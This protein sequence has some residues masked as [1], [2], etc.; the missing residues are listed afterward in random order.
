MKQSMTHTL[1]PRRGPRPTDEVM[2]TDLDELER[3]YRENV[4]TVYRYASSRLGK[5]RGEEITGDVFHAA[6]VAFRQ[7]RGHSVTTA[8]LVAVCK[9]K[10][11][12]EWR[13]A[14]SRR[15]K[16]LLL[17]PDKDDLV[18]F[19]DDWHHDPRREQVMA[20][21]DRCSD[22]HRAVL[23]LHYVDSMTAV[24]IAASLDM[25]TSAIESLLA[26]ARRSFRSH[27]EPELRR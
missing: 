24:E 4:T 27:Y 13:K 11:I 1:R 2:T 14:T 3:I 23:I 15:T 26:R 17:Q 22:A 6:A 16:D 9:N 20:A 19:P 5:D 25:S 21:L 10:V 8:W 12:D 7:G 18:A